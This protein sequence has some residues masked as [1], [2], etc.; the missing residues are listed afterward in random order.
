MLICIA[1]A[2]AGM[3]VKI[4]DSDGWGTPCT[5]SAV[6]VNSV[7]GMN[8]LCKHTNTLRQVFL[9]VFR[10]EIANGNSPYFNAVLL[11]AGL[12]TWPVDIQ[13]CFVLLGL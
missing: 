7:S 9:E 1:E 5:S 6:H 11:V 8:K 3:H 13:V 12:E 2:H 10:I 4:S